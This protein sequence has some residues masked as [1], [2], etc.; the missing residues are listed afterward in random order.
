M[1]IVTPVPVMWEVAR[2]DEIV[3]D[4]EREKRSGGGGWSL[5]SSTCVQL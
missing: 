4:I 2:F 3:E 5:M 1:P